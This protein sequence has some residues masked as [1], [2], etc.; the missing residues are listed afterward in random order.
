MREK[1]QTLMKG[2]KNSVAVVNSL[3][4]ESKIIKEKESRIDPTTFD[5][6]ETTKLEE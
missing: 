1:L 6:V 2:L 5:K 3:D 4:R